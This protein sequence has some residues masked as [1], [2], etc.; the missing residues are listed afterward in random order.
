MSKSRQGKKRTPHLE[1]TKLKISEKLKG[2]IISDETRH[3]MSL[4]K[5]GRKLSEEHKQKISEKLKGKS[6]S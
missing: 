5:V 1:S 2:K 6:K 4:A 3:K